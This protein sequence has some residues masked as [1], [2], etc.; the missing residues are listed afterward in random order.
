MK[1]NVKFILF[2]FIT[3]CCTFLSAQSG[4]IPSGGATSASTAGIS[5]MMQGQNA[6]YH[7][8]AALTSFDKS[9]AFDVSYENKYG[10]KGLNT[11]GLGVLKKSGN[12]YFALGLSQFGLAEYKEQNIFLSYARPLSQSLSLGTT[13][14]RNQLRIVDYGSTSFFSFDIGIHSKINRQLRLASSISNFLQSKNTA[15]NS[16]TVLSIGLAYA[17]SDKVELMLEFQKIANRPMSPKI[18]IIY[19]PIKTIE[20]RIGSDVVKGEYG[21]GIGYHVNQ[22]L[23]R[24]GYSSHLQ[25]GGSYAMTLQGSF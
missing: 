12:S 11:I 2:L 9:I 6:I 1:R 8:A 17:P 3:R 13:M 15:N 7:N 4:F 20:L 25:L 5:T 19:L 24:L 14:H 21:M 23:I 10:I 18:A 16:P 22:Y